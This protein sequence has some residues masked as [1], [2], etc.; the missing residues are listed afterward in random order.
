MAS[1]IGYVATPSLHTVV[2][3]SMQ[4]KTRQN[5]ATFTGELSLDDNEKRF[6]M[7]DSMFNVKAIYP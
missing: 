7:F 1:C 4:G 5:Q 6:Q 2:R 3:L